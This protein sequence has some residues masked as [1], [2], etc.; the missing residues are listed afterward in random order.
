M[1]MITQYSMLGKY[2]WN[3]IKCLVLLLRFGLSSS[4]IPTGH[5]LHMSAICAVSTHSY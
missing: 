1:M 4:E 3:V 5:S 2:F